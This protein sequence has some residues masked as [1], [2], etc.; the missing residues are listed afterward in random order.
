MEETR[1]LSL[2]TEAEG[3][4]TWIRG[5]PKT[6]DKYR[7]TDDHLLFIDKWEIQHAVYR[8]SVAL[9]ATWGLTAV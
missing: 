1:S 5:L 6:N 4:L 2:S 8:N 9:N 3:S 7:R